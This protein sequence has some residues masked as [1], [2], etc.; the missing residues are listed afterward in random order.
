MVSFPEVIKQL[1]LAL[2][3]FYAVVKFCTM[4]EMSL[5]L[6]LFASSLFCRD[7]PLL[8]QQIVRKGHIKGECHVISIIFNLSSSMVS[9]DILEDS[10]SDFAKQAANVIYAEMIRQH[11]FGEGIH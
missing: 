3:L 10:D 4:S 9:S 7:V 8:M 1:A 2:I 5:I 6:L 11:L